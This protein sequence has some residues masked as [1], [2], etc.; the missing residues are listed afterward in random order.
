MAIPKG[1]IWGFSMV[2]FLVPGGADHG[3]GIAREA[4]SWVAGV[5]CRVAGGG[6]LYMLRNLWC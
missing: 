3:H 1:K 6:E 5:Q 2:K 4:H